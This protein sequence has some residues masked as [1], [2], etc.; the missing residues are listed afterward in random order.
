MRT[1]AVTSH[2]DTV[3]KGPTATKRANSS[4]KP[5]PSISKRT[6][7]ALARFPSTIAASQTAATETQVIGVTDA[8]RLSLPTAS[9][10]LLLPV[11]VAGTQQPLTESVTRSS[12]MRRAS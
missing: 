10:T 8:S 4:P 12:F 1:P 3:V 2:P 11:H 6:K 9:P 7:V 5:A